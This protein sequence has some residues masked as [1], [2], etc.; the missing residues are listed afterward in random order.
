MFK[1]TAWLR[2]GCKAS[3]SKWRD[4]PR[5]TAAG[6][7][8]Y[9]SARGAAPA[10]NQDPRPGDRAAAPGRRPLPPHAR[11]GVA[12]A[13]DHPAARSAALVEEPRAAASI[14]MRLSARHLLES[15]ESRSEP[16][17]NSARAENDDSLTHLKNSP[18]R[19]FRAGV[20][21]DQGEIRKLADRCDIP[22]TPLVASP[23]VSWR[24]AM[25]ASEPL[26]PNPLYRQIWASQTNVDHADAP[27]LRLRLRPELEVKAP[28]QG[29]LDSKTLAG[30]DQL[31]SD[32]QLADRPAGRPFQAPRAEL[33]PQ[34]HPAQRLLR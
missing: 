28:R 2:R 25:P 9:E 8:A 3:R 10:A 7:A 20:V 6:R 19:P 1:S 16:L 21:Q 11:R 24:N 17:R 29:G 26:L 34:W 31:P 23:Y 32:G 12:P 15:F 18:H 33:I 27:A 5:A 13:Q 4:S 22:Q 14:F 30:L